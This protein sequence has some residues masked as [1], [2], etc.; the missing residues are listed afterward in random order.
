MDIE[1]I[2]WDWILRILIGGLLGGMIGL[3][4]EIRAKGVGV[5]THFIVGLGRALF[6][7]LSMYAFEG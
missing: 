7:I 4:R 1:C 2:N 6:M 3:E 5:R